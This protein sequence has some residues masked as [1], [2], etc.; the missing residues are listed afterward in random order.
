[1]GPQEQAFL[2]DE[3]YGINQSSPWQR[4]LEAG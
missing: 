1:M 4:I 2:R 3:H